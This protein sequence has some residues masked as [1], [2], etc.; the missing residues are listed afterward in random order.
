[1]KKSKLV[2]VLFLSF[3]FSIIAQENLISK[4]GNQILPEKNEWAFSIDASPFLDYVGNFIGGDGLN[5][6][7]KF[8]LLSG[9][10]VLLG[11][12]FVDSKTAYRFGFRLGHN[13]TSTTTK[14]SEIPMTTPSMYVEDILKLSDTN[15]GLTA[16]LE[17]R[18]GK[19]RLQGLYGVEAGFAVG[20]SR[21]TNTYGNSL[22]SSNPGNR[23]IETKPG[24]SFGLGLRAF[25]GAE[26]FVFPK[27]S[28]GGE[29]GWGMAL[30]SFSEGLTI[31]E[32]WNFGGGGYVEIINTPTGKSSSFSFDSDNLNSIFG[33]AG[34]IRLTFHFSL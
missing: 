6:A 21:S 19:T 2:L 5:V 24:G 30:M 20:T 16:G 9:N 26:Y 23:V 4:N 32:R 14:V 31:S 22:S 34:T 25:I 29:L 12:Y 28:L 17:K 11:K 33:P 3:T 18:I 7:P 27:V 10:Q 8:N 15:F 13:S 1:M